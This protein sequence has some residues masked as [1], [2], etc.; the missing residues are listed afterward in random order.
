MIERISQ[1]TLVAMLWALSL[2]AWASPSAS[3]ILHNGFMGENSVYLDGRYQGRIG[4]GD[5]QAYAMEPGIHT[6]RVVRPGGYS[7]VDTRVHLRIGQATQV[8]VIAPLSKLQLTNTGIAPLRVDLEPGTE[9][10]IG[11]GQS[12]LMTVP[13]GRMKLT[14]S[15][16]TRKGEME[17]EQRTVWVEPGVTTRTQLRA[18]GEASRTLVVTNAYH[19]VVRVLVGGQDRGRLEPGRSM[20][21]NVSPGDAYVQLVEVGGLVAYS[22]HVDLRAG[23]ETRLILERRRDVHVVRT[24][25]ASSRSLA[26]AHPSHKPFR[27]GIWFKR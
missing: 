7:M 19:R 10:W 18:M 11:G 2:T 22:G 5:E 3:L 24:A 16:R 9:V 25:T 17:I 12:A 13:A 1:I 27:G 8:H 26:I 6:V 21:L 15:V 4:A 23:Q 14:T 20:R